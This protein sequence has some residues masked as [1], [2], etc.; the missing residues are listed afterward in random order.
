MKLVIKLTVD[1]VSKTVFADKKHSGLTTSL[2]NALLEQAGR[3]RATDLLLL[4]PYRLGQFLDDKHA[5]LDIRAVDE[6]EREFQIELQVETFKTL[7][8]RMLHN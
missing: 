1:V 3:P 8:R 5:I 7:P 2:V 6:N 4:N